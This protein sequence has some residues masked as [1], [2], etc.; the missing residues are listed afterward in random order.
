MQLKWRREEIGRKMGVIIKRGRALN[1]ISENDLIYR[2]VLPQL[3][4]LQDV[5]IKWMA[6]CDRENL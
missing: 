2:A 4:N 5:V 6:S 3:F 1:Q